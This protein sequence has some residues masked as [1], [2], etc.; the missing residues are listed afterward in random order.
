MEVPKLLESCQP[1]FY[2]IVFTNSCWSRHVNL[3]R[4]LRSCI[5]CHLAIN[6]IYKIIQSLPRAEYKTANEV[7]TW[8]NHLPYPWLP[9]WHGSLRG[10]LSYS[11]NISSLLLWQILVFS[12]HWLTGP[13]SSCQHDPT[14]DAL[15]EE[16]MG[17]YSFS[18]EEIPWG[19]GFLDAVS[20]QGLQQCHLGLSD[21]KWCHTEA[22]EGIARWKVY[23]W[24]LLSSEWQ[25]CLQGNK[26]FPMSLSWWES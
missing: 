19:A 17:F 4:M 3:P 10:A 14:V 12:E 26:R 21:S 25:E 6:L 13:R 11:P 22:G 23:H 16:G 5:A 1:Q 8:I 7:H 20:Y 18:E 24:E 9:C 15:E 2:G